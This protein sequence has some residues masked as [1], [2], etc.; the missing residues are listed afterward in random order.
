MVPG[1]CMQA[2]GWLGLRC[3]CPGA[4]LEENAFSFARLEAGKAMTSWTSAV[5]APVH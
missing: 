3:P 2:A 4:W 5:S 1:G